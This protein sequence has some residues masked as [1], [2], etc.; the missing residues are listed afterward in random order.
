MDLIHPSLIMSLVCGMRIHLGADA[1]HARNHAGLRL[2]ARH[3]SE[4]GSHEEHSLHVL[5]RA[6]DA[7]GLQLLACGIHHSDGSAV[8]DALRADIHI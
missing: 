3:S 6:F 2:R 5:L 4:A 7:T 1:H 8:H